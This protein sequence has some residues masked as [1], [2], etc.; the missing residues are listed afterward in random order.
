MSAL[1]RNELHQIIYYIAGTEHQKLQISEMADPV[2]FP[3]SEAIAIN[4]NSASEFPDGTVVFNA[5]F[6]APCICFSSGV[7]RMVL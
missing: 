4:W 5:L 1:L 6:N 3:E 7:Q 2:E